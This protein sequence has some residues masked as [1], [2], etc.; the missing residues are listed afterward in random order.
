MEGESSSGVRPDASKVT[1]TATEFRT[2]P[3]PEPECDVQCPDISDRN[4]TELK[5]WP[6]ER[7]PTKPEPDAGCWAHFGHWA[8]GF[9][10]NAKVP[11]DACR[12]HLA[13]ERTFLGWVRTSISLAILGTVIAQLFRIQPSATPAPFDFYRL[14]VPLASICHGSALL[15]VLVGAQRYRIQQNAMVVGRIKAGGWEPW[16]VGSIIAMVNYSG[17]IYLCTMK[18]THH[19]DSILSFCF[20]SCCRC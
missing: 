5:S 19:I 6:S 9:S 17:K 10:M 1:E 8:Y 13:N 4:A 7:V 16:F 15:L 20:D 18:L 11:P 2:G 3:V 12:D 14:G